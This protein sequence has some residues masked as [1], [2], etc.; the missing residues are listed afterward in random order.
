MVAKV[1]RGGNSSP[2][3]FMRLTAALSGV[4][5]GVVSCL[6][7]YDPVPVYADVGNFAGAADYIL[8][9]TGDTATFITTPGGAFVAGAV[10]G[11]YLCTRDPMYAGLGDIDAS[12]VS[13]ASGYYLW[14]GDIHTCYTSQISGNTDLSGVDGRVIIVQGTDFSVTAVCNSNITNAHFSSGLVY[15]VGTFNFQFTPY[16]ADSC[17]FA[18]DSP[19][20]DT[21]TIPVGKYSTS[22]LSEVRYRTSGDAVE[23]GN[24]SNSY[25]ASSCSMNGASPFVSAIGYSS[26]PMGTIN[27]DSPDVYLENVLRPY[28]VENYPEYIYLLPEPEPEPP[29]YATDDI[30]PGIPKDW[31]IINPQLPTSPHLDLTIPEGDFQEIDPGDTFTGFASGV[32]FWWSMVNEILNTFHIKTL[33]LALLA[34]AVA[35]F[36][37]YKIGG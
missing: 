6:S 16:S 21:S 9:Q 20:S 24:S 12:A 37:L 27:L 8:S 35:I 29:Q 1:K 2:A 7:W 5:L 15:G 22:F 28:V 4:A 33:A 34:V 13:F 11:I 31:T 18:I 19:F 32:G 17:W 25:L 26:L 30:V 23:L 36:A 10:V 14:N 3:I